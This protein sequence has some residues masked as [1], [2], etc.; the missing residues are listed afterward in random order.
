VERV[1]G[2][3]WPRGE[4][5]KGKRGGLESKKGKNL[6]RAGRGQAALLIVSWAILLLSSNCG[7]EH[8]WLLSGNCGGGV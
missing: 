5:G 2:G 6:K 4:G 3:A 7:E 8:T 1:G